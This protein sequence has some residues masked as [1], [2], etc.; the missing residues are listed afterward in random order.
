MGLLAA[1]AL[2][3]YYL[4]DWPQTRRR[5]PE[6]LAVRWYQ[7]LLHNHRSTVLKALLLLKG[8]PRIIVIKTSPGICPTKPGSRFP[9]SSSKANETQAFSCGHSRT[10]SALIRCTA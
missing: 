1:A 6:L 3:L 4:L 2:M 5:R 10:A 7:Y 9:V 8:N